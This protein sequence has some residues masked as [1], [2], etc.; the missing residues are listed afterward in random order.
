MKKLN[1]LYIIVVL[2]LMLSFNNQSYAVSAMPQ[3]DTNINVTVKETVDD[4][5]EET[6]IIKRVS[7]RDKFKRSP[8]AQINSFFKK[9]NRYSSKNNIE[10]LKEL[11]SDDYINNDGFNKETIFKMMEMAS[12]A[13]KDV[14]YVTEI[15]SIKVEG[16]YAVVNAHELA[17][18]ETI[19]EIEKLKDTGSITS[20]IYYTDYLRKDGN[21]WKIIATD[22][23]SEKVELKY[24]EAKNMIVDIC[25]PQK[26]REGS[27]YEVTMKTKTPDGVFAVGS[28]V[29]EP[30]VYPQIQTKDVFRS[31]KS[32]TLSRILTSNKDQNNEYATVS[33]AITRAHVQPPSLVLNMTG[34]AFVMKR[35][36]VLSLN[37][38]VKLDKEKN[39][40]K[41]TKN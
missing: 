14:S 29:N 37:K 9:Y 41:T 10:K 34:M 35:V 21:K 18:G 6:D 28:I 2:A 30:I 26:V 39:D 20:E 40:V 3:K 19:K 32:E 12:G 7:L 4:D 8:E 38:N 22:I 5:F 24:G 15:E 16:N 17:T 31:I 1:G 23:N 25:A 33:I 11:Y 27:E 36:N 13:Y